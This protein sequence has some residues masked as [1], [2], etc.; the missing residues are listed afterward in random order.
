MQAIY[1]AMQRASIEGDF[2]RKLLA[3]ME[4]RGVTDH[5]AL[6]VVRVARNQADIRFESRRRQYARHAQRAFA[7]AREA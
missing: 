7:S 5:V 6:S 1:D 3:E 4:F 2:A